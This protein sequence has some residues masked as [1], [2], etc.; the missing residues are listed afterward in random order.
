M[1]EC[2]QCGREYSTGERVCQICSEETAFAGVPKPITPRAKV[3]HVLGMAIHTWMIGMFVPTFVASFCV[4]L[5]GDTEFPLAYVLPTLVLISCTALVLARRDRADIRP[6]HIALGWA[7]WPA[8]G[9]V[10]YLIFCASDPAPQADTSR[11]L[12]W[13]FVVTPASGVVG[14]IRGVRGRSAPEPLSSLFWCIVLITGCCLSAWWL[15]SAPFARIFSPRTS[16][17]TIPYTP[18]QHSA[19]K[20]R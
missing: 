5:C 18:P 16:T 9:G 13:L 12:C 7:I 8:V 17:F 15:P 3:L 11:M 1:P 6:I 14:M 4:C 2:P 20:S 10:L 19:A